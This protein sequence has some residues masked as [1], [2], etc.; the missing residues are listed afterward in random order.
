MFAGSHL[1]CVKCWSLSWSEDA[2]PT[3]NLLGVIIPDDDYI[4][5]TA[6]EVSSVNGYLVVSVTKNNALVAATIKCDANGLQC[7]DL[8]SSIM[9]GLQLTGIYIK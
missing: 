4:P 5:V 7:I 9:P 8:Q 3:C 2:A 6:I 1:G